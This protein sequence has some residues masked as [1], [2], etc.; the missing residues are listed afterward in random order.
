MTEEQK[1]TM[2]YGILRMTVDEIANMK[3][4]DPFGNGN[5]LCDAITLARKAKKAVDEAMKELVK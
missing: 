3:G 5:D 4:K 2:C 1:I